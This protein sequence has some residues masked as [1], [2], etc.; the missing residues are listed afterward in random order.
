MPSIVLYDYFARNLARDLTH[1]LYARLVKI[2]ALV[3]LS[4]FEEAINMLITVQRGE[5]LPHFIDDKCKT[6]SSSNVKHVKFL[7]TFR[8]YLNSPKNKYI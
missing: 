6:Y 8:L 7:F 5:H 3:K 1:A 4:L 2:E